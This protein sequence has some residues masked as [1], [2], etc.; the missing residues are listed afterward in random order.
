MSAWSGGKPSAC[1]PYYPSCTILLPLHE[2]LLSRVFGM[3]SQHQMLK[4]IL[5]AAC[6]SLP[7]W[8]QSSP[9]AGALIVRQSNTGSGE[10]ATISSAVAALAGL[11]GPK[12]IFVYPGIYQSVSAKSAPI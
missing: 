4:T 5:A 7:T 8:A 10:H 12:T 9:P 11:T 1:R 2:K 6:F 3:F